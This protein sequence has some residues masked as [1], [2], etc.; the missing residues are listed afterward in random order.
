MPIWMPWAIIS[1]L[2]KEI[3]GVWMVIDSPSTPALVARLARFWKALMN[4]GLQSGYPE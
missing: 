3:S 4:S 1:A 2:L